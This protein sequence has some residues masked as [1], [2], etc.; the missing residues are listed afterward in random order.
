MFA[1]HFLSRSPVTRS[2]SPPATKRAHSVSTSDVTKPSALLVPNIPASRSRMSSLSTG[3]VEDSRRNRERGSLLEDVGK[4]LRSQMRARARKAASTA[5]TSAYS[6]T[7]SLSGNEV[8]TLPY[9]PS[10]VGMTHVISAHQAGSTADGQ[11]FPSASPPATPR[12]GSSTSRSARTS[13]RSHAPRPSRS[14][15]SKWAESLIRSSSNHSNKPAVPIS[16]A[17]TA[18]L[19]TSHL[20]PLPRFDPYEKRRRSESLS[21]IVRKDISMDKENQQ[22]HTPSKVR[23]MSTWSCLRAARNPD[24]YRPNAHI[25][26]L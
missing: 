24:V 19:L 25:I 14:K 22:S 12:L 23:R 17:I 10:S 16:S 5:D 6:S 3:H 13:I 15:S 21:A 1:S 9:M 7:S 26:A 2:Q 20:A 11:A 8:S 4:M 18:D